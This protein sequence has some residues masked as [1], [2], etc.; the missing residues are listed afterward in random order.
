MDAFVEDV[1]VQ[2]AAVCVLLQLSETS[3]GR[4]AVAADGA[5]PRVFAA[6]DINVKSELVRQPGGVWSVPHARTGAPALNV[7]ELT[8]SLGCVMWDACAGFLFGVL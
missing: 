4:R 5:I 6:M 3:P 8:G 2:E 7:P 1:K